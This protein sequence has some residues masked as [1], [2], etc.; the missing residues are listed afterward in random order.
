MIWI[1]LQME[2]VMGVQDLGGVADNCQVFRVHL[3]Y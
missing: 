1:S 3:G 2:A